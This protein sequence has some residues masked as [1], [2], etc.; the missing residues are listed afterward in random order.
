MCIRVINKNKLQLANIGMVIIA[1]VKEALPN[2]SIKK[3]D[4]SSSSYR[5]NIEKNKTS[6]WYEYSF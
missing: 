1:V 5:S 6:K 2:M 3:S 4:Y